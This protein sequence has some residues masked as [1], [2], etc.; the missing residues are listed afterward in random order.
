MDQN[1]VERKLVQK[2]MSLIF[3]LAMMS[4]SILV[5]VL[6]IYMKSLTYTD[7]QIGFTI[8]SAAFISVF[9]SFVWGTLDDKMRNTQYLLT[10]ILI[11]MG[12]VSFVLGVTKI[13]LLFVIVRMLFESFNSGFNPL[14][15][16]TT[17][18]ISEHYDVPFNYMRVFGSIGYSLVLFPVL[19]LVERFNNYFIIFIVMAGCYLLA[20]LSA[21]LLKPLKKINEKHDSGEKHSMAESLKIILRNPAFIL[22]GAVYI[23]MYSITDVSGNFQGIHIVDTLK[24]PAI[25]VSW[26]TFIAS[27]ISE[28]PFMFLGPKIQERLST[29][30][31]LLLSCVFYII[32]F[33]LEGMAPTWQLFLV[34]KLMHGIYISLM[35][36]PMLLLVRRHVHPS[37]YA[38]AVSFL[39][40]CK[41]IGSAFLAP[42]VG[43]VADYFGSTFATYPIYIGGMVLALVLLIVYRKKYEWEFSQIKKVVE[44]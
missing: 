26:A 16:K 34:I 17:I 22:V 44:K 37:L 14:A 8:G 10:I 11:G 4:Y 41:G 19:F 40:A 32:R 5:A 38:T 28:V 35:F 27:G 29:F 36:G 7:T 3:L 12:I 2:G 39:V 24:A 15:D 42:V 33:T 25:V 6:P 1:Q 31:C 23:L 13:Y 9:F 18:E 20:A 43:T 30:T 21:R